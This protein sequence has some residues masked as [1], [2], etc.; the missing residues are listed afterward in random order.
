MLFVP[1][2]GGGFG[3]FL[4]GLGIL[5]TLLEAEEQRDKGR[6]TGTL[7]LRMHKALKPSPALVH[8]PPGSVCTE[9][10]ISASAGWF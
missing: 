6:R 2:L 10:S 9:C 3:D 1:L 8:S 4:V 5:F 7:C